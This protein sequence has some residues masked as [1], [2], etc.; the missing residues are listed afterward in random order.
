MNDDPRQTMTR[1]GRRAPDP[2]EFDSEPR[3]FD[4]RSA[5]N[6]QPPPPPAPRAA[7]TGS[8][9]RVR[10]AFVMTGLALLAFA[11]GLLLFN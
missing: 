10:A 4:L 2:S 3:L 6:P 8:R 9:H 1:R 5:A 7:A 11:T